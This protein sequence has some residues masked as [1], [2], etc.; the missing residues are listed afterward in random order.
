[1][2]TQTAFTAPHYKATQVGQAILDQGGTAC[3]AMVAAAAMVAVQYPH[4]NSLGG[5]SFWLISKKRSGS[6]CD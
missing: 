5:D 3:E 2:T 1:M 4:M 6:D